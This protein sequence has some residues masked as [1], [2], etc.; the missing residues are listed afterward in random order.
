MLGRVTARSRV[1]VPPP[2]VAEHALH[3]PQSLMVQS[4]AHSNVLHARRLASGPHALPP[5]DAAV[6]VVRERFCDPIPHVCVHAVQVLQSFTT[7]SAAHAS[8]LHSRT[9]PRFGHT[10]AAPFCVTD[11][12]RDW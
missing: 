4:T 8:A 10:P 9:S 3:V 2:H 5:C 11:R 7:Q 1:A 6:R 12:D